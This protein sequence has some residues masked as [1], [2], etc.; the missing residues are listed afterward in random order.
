MTRYPPTILGFAPLLAGRL[1]HRAAT[2]WAGSVDTLPS[3]RIVVSNPEQGTWDA[4][5]ARWRA[6]EVFRIGEA[7]GT[8]AAV[9]GEIAAVEVDPSFACGRWSARRRNSAPFW[10]GSS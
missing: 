3:G 5:G 8:G 10:V 2:R 4:G 6:E 7:D 9:F 1:E